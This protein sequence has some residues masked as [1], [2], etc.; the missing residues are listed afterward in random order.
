[1]KLRAQ[2][3]LVHGVTWAHAPTPDCAPP[4]RR[5]ASGDLVALASVDDIAAL[6]DCDDDAS[7]P[8]AA[9][10]AETKFAAEAD[11]SL[12]READAAVRHQH[13]LTAYAAQGAVVPYYFGGDM[14]SWTGASCRPISI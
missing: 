7:R 8:R 4:H 14:Q 13:L 1:M 11:I 5:V 6:P 9:A 10:V 2:S 12:R 3:W